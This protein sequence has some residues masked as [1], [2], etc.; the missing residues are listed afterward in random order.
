MQTRPPFVLLE[1]SAFIIE[2]LL[3]YGVSSLSRI[4][5]SK[6]VSDKQMMSMLFALIN[7]SI[8]GTLQYD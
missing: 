7:V 1:E 6:N 5:E 2:H 8:Q 3:I 4:V